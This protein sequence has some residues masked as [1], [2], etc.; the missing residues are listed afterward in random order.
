MTNE[1]ADTVKTNGM[2]DADLFAVTDSVAIDGGFGQDYDTLLR[3]YLVTDDNS[4][5]PYI[6][7]HVVQK[8]GPRIIDSWEE[9][10]SYYRDQYEWSYSDDNSWNPYLEVDTSGATGQNWEDFGTGIPN[11]TTFTEGNGSKPST[12]LAKVYG[13]VKVDCL[14]KGKWYWTVSAYNGIKR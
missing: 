7:S 14:P 1:E 9:A 4:Q 5:T 3:S 10:G 11:P 6:R 8:N 12:N 13:T 2:T